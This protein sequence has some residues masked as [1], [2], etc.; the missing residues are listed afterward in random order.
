MTWIDHSF[1]ADRFFP[2]LDKLGYTVT[3]ESEPQEE[4]G[5]RYTFRKY[6]KL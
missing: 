5:Y 2:D 6:E 1:D 3:W 4:A